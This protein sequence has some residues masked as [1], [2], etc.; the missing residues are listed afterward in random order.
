[1]ENILQS[2]LALLP[3]IWLIVA[4]SGLKMAGHKAC[5]GA[6]IVSAVLALFFWK[7][8]ALD[9]ASA[10]LEGAL[11]ALWPIILVIIAAIFT[12]NLSLHT[13]AMDVIKQMITGVS[14]DSR[15]LALLVGWCFSGFLEGMAGFGTA[16]AIPAGM[17]AGMGMN[18]LTAAVICLLANAAPTAFGSIGIPTVTLAK[19]TG[20]EAAPLALLTVEQ[21]APYMI[22]VPFIM[23]ALVGGGLKAIKGV[24]GV[25]LVASLSFFIP[26]L[27]V[28][29]FLGAE[30]PV[31]VGSVCSLACTIG[32][33]K[34]FGKNKPVP[35]AYDM[36]AHLP[37]HMEITGKKALVSW[38]PFLLIFVFLLLISKLIP[39]LYAVLNEIHT[40]ATIFTGPNASPYTFTWIA[41]P[42]VVI[43]LA[44]V[45]GGLA[46]GASG[47]EMWKVL[48]STVKQMSKTIVTII[49]VLA[50]ARIMS[51]SGMISAIAAL[52]VGV[53]GGFYPFVAPIIGA[54]GAFVTGSG[55]SA[56]VLLGKLQ[57]EAA[58]AVGATPGWLAA[59]NTL[60]ACIGKI[61]SPQCISIAVAATGMDGQDGKILGTVI[62]WAVG[63][64]VVACLISGL[65][66]GVFVA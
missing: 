45:I 32:A 12:Y 33:A 21:L 24:F 54:L 58:L 16:V 35:E 52:F 22:L 60:G 48:V 2:I 55:T 29:K 11:M 61:I 64:L 46:Q 65:L 41:T 1:M 37:E 66:Q 8:P 19:V 13:G 36:R 50:T 62:K 56:E 53:A 27:A 57:V 25:T 63:M 7:M 14:A 26:E 10:A 9:C 59:A 30:L 34:L 49:A 39:P 4:L 40:T 23:V 38:L 3:I 17:L 6:L 44:A 47:G 5:I 31:V 18:P 15:V 51:Y 43:F 20:L 28:A 42:G